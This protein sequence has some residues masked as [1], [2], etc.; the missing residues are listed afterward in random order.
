MSAEIHLDK[1]TR[2][3]LGSEAGRLLSGARSAIG[4][5]RMWWLDDD[6]RPDRTRGQQLWL[7][8]RLTHLFSLGD[9]LGR[10]GD[11]DRADVGLASIDRDFGDEQHGGW[12]PRVEP[13]GK[14]VPAKTA[15]EHA[16][17]MLAA[18]SATV[19]QRPGAADLL[20]RASGVVL[21]RFWDEDEGALL[22]SWDAPWRAAEDYR[23]ANANMHAVEAFLAAGDATGDRA[24]WERARRICE[25]VINDA[26][27]QHDWRVP[28][29][30]DASWVF[31]PD[32]NR[33][34]PRHPFRPYGATPGHGLEWA[35][36]LLQL[37]S[38]LPGGT[39]WMPDAA[40]ALFAR[41]IADGWDGG[42]LVYT[43]DNSGVPVVRERFHWVVCE[44]M[45][46]AWALASTTGDQQY[47]DWFGRLWQHAQEVFIDRERGG[48]RHEV[49]EHNRPSS[50][51]WQGKPDWY[52]AAQAMLFPLLDMSASFAG[53]LR[54]ERS[55]PG[56]G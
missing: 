10:A 15:Y 41:A 29:H 42:G 2:S 38:Q 7:T 32:Y 56:R 23:G 19:A 48:W 26:A 47:A 24:W 8:A 17:V 18:A 11:A 6:L 4:D 3:A 28:E 14:A 12:F 36:L 39:G 31:L 43:T 46:T 1:S 54:G 20:E 51:T 34:Q 27:R 13:D 16:F 45:A 40:A 37:H 25:R 55:W 52:H 50:T 30:F 9:L 35:R 33:D 22:E 5:D 21:Q 44:G 53:A 49:D